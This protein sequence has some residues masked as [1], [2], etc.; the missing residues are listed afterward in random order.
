VAAVH[1]P[2]PREQEEAMGF[3]HDLEQTD[4][5]SVALVR[6]VQNEQ[7]QFSQDCRLLAIIY[8]KNVINRRWNQ[9]MSLSISLYV[10][11]CV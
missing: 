2:S 1:A 4:G 6:V 5:L 10:Y 7:E 3:L 11:E 9:V 8:L